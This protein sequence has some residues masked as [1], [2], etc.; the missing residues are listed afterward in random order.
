MTAAPN[1]LK[2]QVESSI[3]R[4]NGSFVN[5]PLRTLAGWSEIYEKPPLIVISAQ[6]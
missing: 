6:R 5:D 3:K 4:L 2:A 1:G